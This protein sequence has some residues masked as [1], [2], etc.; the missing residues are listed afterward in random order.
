MCRFILVLLLQQGRGNA[1]WATERKMWQPAGAPWLEICHKVGPTAAAH[2]IALGSTQ[3]NAA[4]ARKGDASLVGRRRNEKRKSKSNVGHTACIAGGLSC[5]GQ[6]SGK[7]GRGSCTRV[8]PLH[9]YKLQQSQS[10]RT[11]CARQRWGRSR[12]LCSH[13]LEHKRCRRSG[14]GCGFSHKCVR[15]RQWL[16]AVGAA[17]QAAGGQ[18]QGLEHCEVAIQPVGE[19]AGLGLAGGH[20]LA[21]EAEVGQGNEH[22]ADLA[23]LVQSLQRSGC[24]GRRGV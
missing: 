20:L 21:A 3:V 19:A 24:C 22:T 8:V 18:G 10:I 23:A 15:C 11:A 16:R 6:W 2:A 7:R 17:Q 1:G 4:A 5:R 9:C 14:P 12:C 13:F